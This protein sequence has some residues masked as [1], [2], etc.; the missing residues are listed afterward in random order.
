[1]ALNRQYREQQD[2]RRPALTAIIPALM[3]L[4]V[5]V[6]FISIASSGDIERDHRGG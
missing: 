2:N 1:M 4:V 6:T 5:S 3:N